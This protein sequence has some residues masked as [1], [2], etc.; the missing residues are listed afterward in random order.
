M[1][2]ISLAFAATAAVRL[3]DLDVTQITSG[4]GTAQVNRTVD[5]N[6][7]RIAGRT[8]TNGIGTHAV[9]GMVIQLAGQAETFRA[10]V[11]VDD[12]VAPKI[13]SVEFRVL[14][15][16]RQL[17]TSGVMKTGDAAR[18]VNVSLRGVKQLML[19]AGDGGNGINNNHADWGEV[20][21]LTWCQS[22]MK[23]ATRI[24][25]KIKN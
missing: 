21:C 24:V 5:G 8:F 10:W 25:C 1:V 2:C 12:E 11:G 20:G 13:G 15:D 16:G 14:G 4:W 9:G 19:L 17:W 18:Q 23:V 22:G 6:P 7:L 3:T